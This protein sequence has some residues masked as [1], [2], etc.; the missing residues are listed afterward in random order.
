LAKAKFNLVDCLDIAN[1]WVLY[2]NKGPR[3]I[4][5]DLLTGLGMNFPIQYKL[6]GSWETAAG[7]GGYKQIRIQEFY[8]PLNANIAKASCELKRKTTLRLNE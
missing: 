6:V 3:S 5:V 2:E 7:A 8:K 4:S 1:A